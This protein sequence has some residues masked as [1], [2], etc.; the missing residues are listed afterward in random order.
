MCY[1]RESRVLSHIYSL[2]T[3]DGVSGA[4]MTP[5][6]YADILDEAALR[7]EISR[8][9]GSNYAT[10]TYATGY[11]QQGYGYSQNYGSYGSYGR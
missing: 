1:S 4:A 6:Q 8:N 10:G 3:V 9:T 2:G 11:Y 5:K 7:A